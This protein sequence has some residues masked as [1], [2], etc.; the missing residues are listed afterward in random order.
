MSVHICALVSPSL[1]SHIPLHQANFIKILRIVLREIIIIIII[2]FFLSEK[3]VF[4]R[5]KDHFEDK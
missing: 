4:A 3:R 1:L 5:I 2:I